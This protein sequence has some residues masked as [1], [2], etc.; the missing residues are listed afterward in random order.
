MALTKA[1]KEGRAWVS[2]VQ[3][4]YW[5]SYNP[6]S[7]YAELLSTAMTLAEAKVHI[8]PLSEDGATA[9]DRAFAAHCG[10]AL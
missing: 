10:E 1:V 5:A 8:I 2:Q 3:E 6:S 7:G 9:D 4:V